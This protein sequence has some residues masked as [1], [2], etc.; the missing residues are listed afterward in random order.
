[1]RFI[2]MHG[3]VFLMA[4]LMAVAL[5]VGTFALGGPEE[6]EYYRTLNEEKRAAREAA[7]EQ[8]RQE[9]EERKQQERE[10]AERK[11]QEKIDC[12]DGCKHMCDGMRGLPF[13]VREP[14]ERES[15]ECRDGCNQ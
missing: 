7:E 15:R 13:S 4:A 12:L 2:I 8:R 1:M 3:R 6:E 14:C 5:G 11:K 9:E 10:E